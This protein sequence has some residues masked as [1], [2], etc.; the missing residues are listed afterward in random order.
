MRAAD[1][2]SSTS[3]S[4]REFADTIPEGYG[5]TCLG[6]KRIDLVDDGVDRDSG[7][8]AFRRHFKDN[9]LQSCK[10]SQRGRMS[11]QESRA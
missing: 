10:G 1:L 3:L 6:E 11:N 4:A 8:L 5:R 9:S 2:V 7:V